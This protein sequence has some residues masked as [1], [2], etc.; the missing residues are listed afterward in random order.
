MATSLDAPEGGDRKGIR[1]NRHWKE[2]WSVWVTRSTVAAAIAHAVLFV[3]WPVWD[4]SRRTS[5][6]SPMEVVQ[7]QPILSSSFVGEEFDSPTTALPSPEELEMDRASGGGSEV[8]EEEMGGDLLAGLNEPDP[9]LAFPVLRGTAYERPA[10]PLPSDDLNLDEVMVHP[11]VANLP[12][13]IAWPLIRNPAAVVRY[14]R[15]RY[16]PV[17]SAPDLT[18]TVSVAMWVNERGSVE[19]SEVR[20]SSGNP[21][22]DQIALVMFNEVV[23]FRPARSRGA[24][25]PVTVVIRVPFDAP[26]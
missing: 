21:L 8:E 17:H 25:V 9:S 11:R 13:T 15:T 20:E 14:L 1:S 7:I 2:R 22:L 5:Q 6:E 19:W 3:L 16:N 18:G 4:I 10:P 12:P 24:P 23:L 26:W